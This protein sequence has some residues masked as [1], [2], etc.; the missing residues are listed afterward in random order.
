M[1]LT[2]LSR[3][4]LIRIKMLRVRIVEKSISTIYRRFPSFYE[5]V[6]N[7]KYGKIKNWVVNDFFRGK[8]ILPDVIK[9][10]VEGAEMKV[11]EGM[12]HLMKYGNLKIFVEV[13]PQRLLDHKSSAKEVIL[14]LLDEGFTLFEIENFRKSGKEINLKRLNRSSHLQDDAMLYASKEHQ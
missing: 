9:I 1:L 6:I 12:K 11:L 13:H 10:D 5:Y 2:G 8:K 7:K 4:Y 14:L 3:F